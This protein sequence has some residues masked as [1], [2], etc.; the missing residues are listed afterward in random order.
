MPT[1]QLPRKPRSWTRRVPVPACY[2]APCRRPNPSW[3]GFLWMK[4]VH[5]LLRVMPTE[6]VPRVPV[7]AFHHAPCLRPDLSWIGVLWMRCMHKC[8]SGTI[9]HSTHG[10]THH[11]C[12][13]RQKPAR[14][15]CPTNQWQTATRH[16]LPSRWVP[17]LVFWPCGRGKSKN[18]RPCPSPAK[19]HMPLPQSI[20][21]A[22]AMRSH[23]LAA[24]LPCKHQTWPTFFT[25][26]ECLA[27]FRFS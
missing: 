2:R 8:Q 23:T 3:I 7:A 26:H 14:L 19:K 18:F 22:W 17:S 13:P 27:L 24:P 16:P 4:S 21:T 15:A 1:K 6:T 12:R 20:G 5:R 25:I 9:F 10:R 11:L